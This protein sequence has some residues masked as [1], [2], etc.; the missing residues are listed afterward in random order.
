MKSLRKALHTK[1][2]LPAPE[3]FLEIGAVLIRTEAEL[4]LKSR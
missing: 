2:G 3:W 1:L 4:I